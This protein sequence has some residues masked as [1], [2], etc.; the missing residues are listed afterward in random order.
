MK[1]SHPTFQLISG[2]V[3][4][5][6]LTGCQT[7]APT[8]Q[9]SS[10]AEQSFDGLHKVDNS[11][12]DEVWAR[13][14]FDLSG[15]TKIMLADTGVEY[16]QVKNRG[17][18]RLERSKTGPFIIDD[19]NRAKFETL[20][21]TAFKEEMQEIEKFS[22]VDK[23]GPDVLLISSSLLDVISY[24]PPDAVGS[25]SHIFLSNVGDATLVLELRDSETSTIL[26]RSVDRRSAETIGHQFKVSNSVTNATE[27]KRLI[28]FWARRL[29][30]NLDSF[31]EK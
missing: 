24:V 10:D 26:A 6:A 7:T 3:F 28:R 4:A 19:D 22:I 13:P 31:I 11:K 17:R 27:V 2:F 23:K 9:S 18:T 5:A 16:R 1:K 30:E 8:I 14:D 25:R 12:A 20:I 29:H 15:Y 21:N